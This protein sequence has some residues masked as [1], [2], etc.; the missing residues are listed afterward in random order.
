M[1]RQVIQCNQKKWRWLTWDPP[2]ANST[3]GTTKCSLTLKSSVYYLGKD[4]LRIIFL[5]AIKGL[6]FKQVHKCERLRKQ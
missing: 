2:P 3:N 6:C 1:L 5:M 4:Y